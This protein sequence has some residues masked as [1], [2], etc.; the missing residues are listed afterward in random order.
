MTK[1][2]NIKERIKTLPKGWVVMNKDN[3]W[4]WWKRKP[5]LFDNG[6][7]GLCWGCNGLVTSKEF[8]NLENNIKPV[9]DWTKSLIKVENDNAG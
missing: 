7:G 6:L 1:Q 3:S 8:K 9:S 4:S 2:I 5:Q